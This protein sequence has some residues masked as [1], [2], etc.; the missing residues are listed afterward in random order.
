VPQNDSWFISGVSRYGWGHLRPDVVQ[1]IRFSP[2]S[3]TITVSGQDTG[4]SF[5]LSVNGI[6]TAAITATSGSAPTAANVKSAIVAVDD[7]IVADDVTVT[8]SNGGPFTVTLPA[9]LSHGTDAVLTST[10]VAA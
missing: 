6:E 7:G 5:T 3:F 2:M 10:V 8:G 1:R 9:V 4:A